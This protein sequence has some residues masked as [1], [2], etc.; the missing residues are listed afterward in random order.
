[1]S[2]TFS[3]FLYAFFILD[4]NVESLDDIFLKS[5]DFSSCSA[6]KMS[7]PISLEIA[8]TPLVKSSF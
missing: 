2:S 3:D 6:F 4:I 8:F 5:S 7:T 1:M